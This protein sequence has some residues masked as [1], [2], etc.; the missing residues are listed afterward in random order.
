MARF[1]RT[2]SEFDLQL[3]QKDNNTIRRDEMLR[4]VNMEVQEIELLV[5][6]TFDA[7]YKTM[8]ST[9]KFICETLVCN[10]WIDLD[11]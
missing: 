11:D 3:I 9:L 5:Y 4:N 2:F 10:A 6:K 7:I 1:H 8:L